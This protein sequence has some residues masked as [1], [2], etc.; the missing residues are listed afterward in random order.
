MRISLSLY[1]ALLSFSCAPPAYSVGTAALGGPSHSP[2]SPTDWAR[3]E[4][5][6]TSFASKDGARP[7]GQPTRLQKTGF[8]AEQ[9]FAVEAGHCYTLGVAW[10]FHRKATG[11]IAFENGADGKPI[12]DTIGGRNFKL[13]PPGGSATFCPDRAGNVLVSVMVVD[14]SGAVAQNELLEFALSLGAKPE[15]ESEATA[16]RERERAEAGR[17]EATMA[18]NIK[19]SE[20]R[21]ERNRQL[22]ARLVRERCPGCQDTDRS[23]QV[24]RAATPKT[25]VSYGPDQSCEVAY[26]ECQWG[27][28][29]TAANHRGEYPCG[30][31][32]GL[33]Q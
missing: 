31:P 21:E 33:V 10:A 15:S 28:G 1:A 2:A 17:A 19:E 4:T 24:G 7:E 18:K 8:S 30:A 22:D 13:D 32:E 3:L 9:R 23:C 25:G 14:E 26:H 16:R 20:A 27:D 11:S 6:A 5:Q 12:N 29:V